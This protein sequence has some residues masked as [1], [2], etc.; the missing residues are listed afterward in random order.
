MGSAQVAPSTPV[1]IPCEGPNMPAACPADSAAPRSMDAARADLAA[2]QAAALA[3]Q[4]RLMMQRHDLN[5]QLY[6]D[7]LNAVARQQASQIN[8]LL[9]PPN[10][11]AAA[12][13]VSGIVSGSGNRE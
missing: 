6:K 5:R 12:Q 8:P 11:R 4:Q 2:R 7:Q 13:V 10:F 9:N 3:Q 1:I